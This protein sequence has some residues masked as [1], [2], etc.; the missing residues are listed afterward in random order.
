M[1]LFWLLYSFPTLTMSS[2]LL[3]HTLL[4]FQPQHEIEL[5]VSFN[6]FEVCIMPAPV[7]KQKQLFY[8]LQ[9]ALGRPASALAVGCTGKA[10]FG[11]SS[12]LHWKGPIWRQQQVALGRPDSVLAVGW[13]RK[14]RFGVSSKLHCAIRLGL[15]C[16]LGK[17]DR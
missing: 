15:R 1:L 5:D 16:K 6:F 17:L 14:A 3:N 7:Y 12:R 11:I 2:D 8:W 9:V 4:T 13:T 10:R